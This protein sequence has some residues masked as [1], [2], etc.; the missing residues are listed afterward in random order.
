M[1]NEFRVTKTITYSNGQAK[2]DFDPGSL[3]LPQGTQGYQHQTVTAT[4][5][6]ADVSFGNVTTPGL[7][8]MQNL[9][10]TTTGGSVDWGPKSTS[11]VLEPMGTLG[12]KQTAD[13]WMNSTT[14]LRIQRTAAG[15]TN[16][17]FL[18]FEN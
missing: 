8:I 2:Y 1:A 5:A 13:L 18:L 14:T 4:S 17:A 6:A 12:P 11:G 7:L 15:N 16:V 10:P 9:D 3:N